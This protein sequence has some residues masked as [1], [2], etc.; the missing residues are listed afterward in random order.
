MRKCH[1]CVQDIPDAATVCPQCGRDLI[2]GRKTDAAPAVARV[3]A[4]EPASSQILRVSVVDVTM[5]FA[6]M[7][8]FM[9]K[10]AIAAIPAFLILAALGA[11]IA[12]LF[13]VYGRP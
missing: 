1:F 8:G 11:L 4:I 12:G 6:S 7:V 5:P 3:A 10:W 13:A 2:P 9:V